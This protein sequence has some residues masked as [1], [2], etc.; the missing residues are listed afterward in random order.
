MKTIK[1]ILDYYYMFCEKVIEHARVVFEKIRKPRAYVC[2][3]LAIVCV[4]AAVCVVDGS[5]YE[6]GIRIGGT[7]GFFVFVL[8]WNALRGKG[9]DDDEND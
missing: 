8:A 9:Q 3:V 4:F 7:L 6:I 1:K 2:A 5:K